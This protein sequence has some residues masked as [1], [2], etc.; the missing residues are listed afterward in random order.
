M[1]R[2]RVVLTVLGAIGCLVLLARLADAQVLTRSLFGK[3][4]DASGGVLRHL[5]RHVQSRR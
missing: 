5:D 1:A 4:K 2:K 3:V